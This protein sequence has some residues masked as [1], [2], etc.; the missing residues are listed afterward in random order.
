MKLSFEQICSITMGYVQAEKTERGIRFYRFTEEQM[1]IFKQSNA[2]FYMRAFAS[3]GI[4]MCFKTDSQKL[5]I[6]VRV[7]EG[8]LRKYFSFD[9][10]VNHKLVGTLNNFFDVKLPK[11]YTT[12]QLPLGE[13]SKLF[14]LGEGTKEVCIYLP[15]SVDVEIIEISLEDKSFIKP[16]KPPK[17]M[18][19]FG[20]SIT[21]GCDALHPSK[22]YTARI[23][24]SFDAEEIN[25]GIGG[26][27]FFPPLALLKDNFEPD[28]ILVAYGSND[29]KKS[30]KSEFMKNCYDFFSALKNNYPNTPIYAI[31]PTW[32]KDMNV[33]SDFGPFCKV[34]EYIEEIVKK[35]KNITFVNGF[36]FIPKDETYFADLRLHPNDKGFNYY[37]SSLYGK[38]KVKGYENY[39]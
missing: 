30:N 27:T 38:M 28:Y 37:F 2:D 33:E 14:L 22:C 4:K 36:D 3:A 1:D 12:L 20:D 21:Q 6:K 39:E 13:F 15:W 34:A 16:I 7:K 26:A 11:N 19:I 24:E 18:L 23:A 31:A 32:R 17:K 10:M 5:F 35:F 9:L 25:K 8:S 29:W